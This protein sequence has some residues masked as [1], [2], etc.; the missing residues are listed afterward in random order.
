M[1]PWKSH[2][3]SM[4]NIYEGAKVSRRHPY[5]RPSPHYTLRHHSCSQLHRL[6]LSINHSISRTQRLRS[7]TH[8]QPTHITIKH[9][10]C[11]NKSKPTF[12][13]SSGRSAGEV[14]LHR[15]DRRAYMGLLFI[16]DSLLS[17][18]IAYHN[19]IIYRL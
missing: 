17:L 16:S 13:A 9:Y 12:S 11:V 6:C 19:Y 18:K 10:L 1:S 5:S 8:S 14:L 3:H 2:D 15:P 4:G 7:T